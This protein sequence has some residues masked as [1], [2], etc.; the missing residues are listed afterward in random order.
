MPVKVV[1]QNLNAHINHLPN[2]YIMNKIITAVISA[3][4][5][6]AIADAAPATPR[7]K[8]TGVRHESARPLAS[9]QGNSASGKDTRH[10]FGTLPPRKFSNKALKI[11]NLATGGIATPADLCG[12]VT[13]NTES[14]RGIQIIPQTPEG[15]F[16]MIAPDIVAN[17]GAV[18][19]DGIY[20]VARSE[21]YLDYTYYIDTYDATNWELIESR[22]TS[23]EL[24]SADMALDPVSGKVYGCFFASLDNISGKETYAFGTADFETLTMTPICSLED[25]F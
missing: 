11:R 8:D 12:S 18:M 13:Y 10:I 19:V 23:I 15:E 21:G 25:K 17:R 7:G 22:E 5:A 2:S 6:V 9:I 3:L 20:Y 14:N 1:L 16:V 24:M 4:L